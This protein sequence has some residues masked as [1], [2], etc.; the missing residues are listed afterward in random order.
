ML[1][2]AFPP[3]A[4]SEMQTSVQAVY[5][6]CSWHLTWGRRGREGNGTGKMGGWLW[7]SLHKSPSWPHRELWVWA[8]PSELSHLSERLG[9][10]VTGWRLCWEEYTLAEALLLA[11]GNSCWQLGA[12][13]SFLKGVLGGALALTL[14]AGCP[15]AWRTHHIV[16]LKVEIPYKPI[17]SWLRGV[18]LSLGTWGLVH[19]HQTSSDHSHQRKKREGSLCSPTSLFPGSPP[20]F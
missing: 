2:F 13:F 8:G 20:L 1:K 14:Q 16:S 15:F 19:S 3:E 17:V 6:E 5:D 12:K 10:L 9:P 4:D 11:W 18:G 7:G